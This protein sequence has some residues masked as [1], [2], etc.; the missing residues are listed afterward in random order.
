MVRKD[1][2]FQ[3]IFKEVFEKDLQTHYQKKGRSVMA[4]GIDLVT[5]ETPF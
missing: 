4:T 2:L 3:R 1:I 5:M